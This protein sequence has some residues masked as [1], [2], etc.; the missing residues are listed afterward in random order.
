MV[1]NLK[2]LYDIVG[3]SQEFDYIVP[4]ERLDE[5][6]GY[7]F[8]DGFAVKGRAYNRA[9]ILNLSFSVT[10]TLEAE[11]DRCL[12]PFEREFSY[13]FDHILVRTVNNDNDEYIVTEGDSIDVDEVALPDALLQMPSKLLC[14]EDC[15]GLCYICGADLNEADCGCNRQR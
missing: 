14:R 2:Q 1:L 13:D 8:A 15:K 11:C 9:G 7:S 4:R 10:F 12:K 3:E 5:I 6:R